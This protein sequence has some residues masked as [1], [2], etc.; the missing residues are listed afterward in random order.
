MV[1]ELT[2]KETRVT[3]GTKAEGEVSFQSSEKRLH[4]SEDH[5]GDGPELLRAEHP[6]RYADRQPPPAGSSR[7]APD[8]ALSL[9]NRIWFTSSRLA[10]RPRILLPGSAM[11][12]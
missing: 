1:E 6:P 11:P 7:G 5:A 2:P 12:W 10:I 4:R 3:R 9:P 8:A